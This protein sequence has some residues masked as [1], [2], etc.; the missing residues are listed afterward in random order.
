MTSSRTQRTRGLQDGKY[1]VERMIA[2]DEA[3]AAAAAAAA[4]TTTPHS[5]K[6]MKE[7]HREEGQEVGIEAEGS[8]S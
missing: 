2:A 6:K 3:A 8:A 1:F 7:V 4:A 5:E